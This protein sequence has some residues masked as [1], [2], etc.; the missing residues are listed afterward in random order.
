MK[1]IILVYYLITL[2]KTLEPRSGKGQWWGWS[3]Y[4]AN[5]FFLGI[6]VLPSSTFL[7]FHVFP[8]QPRVHVIGPS[9]NKPTIAE[10]SA[11]Y[12]LEILKEELGHITPSTR[13]GPTGIR[14]SS[15]NACAL[16]LILK[17]T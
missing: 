2:P 4:I 11:L 16:M 12:S 15:Q 3:I 8:W 6:D 10:P 9:S 7:R 17:A 5:H 14:K 1:Y 13:L